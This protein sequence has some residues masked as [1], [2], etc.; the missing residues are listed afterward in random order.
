M[1]RRL[2]DT[3]ACTRSRRTLKWSSWKG[4]PSGAPLG[5]AAEASA[6]MR[7]PSARWGGCR[8][9]N[10]RRRR[11]HHLAGHDPLRSRPA[12]WGMRARP[13]QPAGTGGE[14]ASFDCSCR[15]GYAG[16]DGHTCALSRVAPAYPAVRE[17]PADQ[18]HVMAR[19]PHRLA[20]GRLGGA[21]DCRTSTRPPSARRCRSTRTAARYLRSP[22]PSLHAEPARPGS[23]PRWGTPPGS[24]RPGAGHRACP[25]C[26]G[27][28]PIL[29]TPAPA[30][31][32]LLE[33]LHSRPRQGRVTL[34][35]GPRRWD[36]RR[37]WHCGAGADLS[38]HPFAFSLRDFRP[39]PWM[40]SRPSD[41]KRS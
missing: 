36:R 23:G 33:C 29:G 22:F 34:S 16:A 4:V 15:A 18:P 3:P 39:L 27:T 24:P 19:S 40:S 8:C 11:I 12:Q 30:A 38:R 32:C 20:L 1:W 6:G 2:T 31:G 5:R 10:S 9:S 17:R 14:P 7:R 26:Q 28:P 13:P 21:S 35:G 37:P 41:R 25:F